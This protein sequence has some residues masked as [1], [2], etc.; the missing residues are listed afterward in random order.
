MEIPKRNDPSDFE[1]EPFEDYFAR[2]PQEL[3]HIPED[4]VKNWMWYHNEQVVEFSQLYDFTKWKFSLEDFDNDKIMEIQHFEYDLKLLDGKGQ[5]FLK[6]CL[7]EHD[8]AKFM[9]ENGTSPCP[10]I[11]TK[12]A[13]NHI[14]HQREEGNL[15]LEP[16]HLIEG[17]R[18]LA[19]LRAMIGKPFP[20]L[21]ESHKVWVVE[22]EE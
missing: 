8:T 10:M 21:K 22:I 19:Y 3:N 15:M 17:N 14:H 13:G 5:E 1:C 7:N 9:F 20:R 4:V 11:V 18:R 16:Y 12:D 6:G 2:F